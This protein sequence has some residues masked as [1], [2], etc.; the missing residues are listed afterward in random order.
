MGKVKVL[1]VGSA[2]ME[3]CMNTYKVPAPGEVVTDDGGVAYVPGGSGVRCGAAFTKL[4]AECRIA[5]RLGR[6]L[7]GQKLYQYFRDL[8]ISTDT[9]KVDKELPTGLAVVI[10]ETDEPMRRIIYP[11]ASGAL[12]C[13][14]ISD[15]VTADVDAVCLRLDLPEELIN[16]AIASASVKGIPTFVCQDGFSGGFNLESLPPVDVFVTDV[17]CAERTV[18]IRPV[19]ADASLRASLALFKAVSCKYIV[20]RQGER[21][22]FIYD[23]KHY[24]MIPAINAGKPSPDAAPAEPFFAALVIRYLLGGGDMK[25]AVQYAAVVAAIAATHGGGI[26]ALPTEKEVISFLEKYTG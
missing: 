4:G 14:D 24:F 11:G 6:D 20:I 19:G 9:V 10:K 17:E 8:G 22:A 15:A 25:S 23:G 1:T 5:S 13:E 26:S 2:Y 21:G 16:A 12:S 3:L 7:H 18:G